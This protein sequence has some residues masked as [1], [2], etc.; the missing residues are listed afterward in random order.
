M[1]FDWK[2]YKKL[3]PAIIGVGLLISFNYLKIERIPGL[4]SIVLEWLIGAGTVFGVY[5][6]KNIP[7]KTETKEVQ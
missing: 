6:S 7:P 4:D 2:N 3:V 5:Q 1:T